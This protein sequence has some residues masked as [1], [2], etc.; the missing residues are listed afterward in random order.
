[1]AVCAVCSQPCRGRCGLCGA[2]LCSLHRPKGV[3]RCAVCPQRR[4]RQS[5]TGSA[6]PVQRTYRVDEELP[7]IL[8]LD[9]TQMSDQDMRLLLQTFQA[10]LVE[11]QKRE[12]NSLLRRD[13]RR[14]RSQ[15]TVPPHDIDADY[16]RDRPFEDRLLAFLQYLERRLNPPSDG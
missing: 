9:F 14:Q 15:G 4:S 2:S 1:M 13:R 7:A 12:A 16:T 11:K 8:S 10:W 5:A 3:Q 6:K